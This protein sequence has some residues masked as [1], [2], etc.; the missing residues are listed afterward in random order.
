MPE[1]R[2]VQLGRRDRRWDPHQCRGAEQLRL[3]RVQEVAL[4]LAQPAVYQVDHD[5]PEIVRHR[6]GRWRACD[7]RHPRLGDLGLLGGALHRDVGGRGGAV[8]P[9]RRRRLLV[10]RRRRE[11][12]RKVRKGHRV[13]HHGPCIVAQR[14]QRVPVLHSPENVAALSHLCRDELSRRQPKEPGDGLQ[15]VGHCARL[16]HPGADL[17]HVLVQRASLGDADHAASY[18]AVVVLWQRNRHKAERI[19]GRVLVP[20]HLATEHGLELAAEEGGDRRPLPPAMRRPELLRHDL[21]RAALA[22]LQLHVRLVPRAVHVLAK[23]GQKHREKLLGVLLSP[24]GKLRLE[25]AD[26]AAEC[27]WRHDAC[28]ICL[29]ALNVGE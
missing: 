2:F 9:S 6:G 20:T 23:A 15:Q 28:A 4:H 13:E 7:R 19:E 11:L 16:R 10:A 5:F 24:A 3:V 12:R 22:V 27:T 21:V 1:H 8:G 25:V 17:H 14:R 26:R 29:G 18:P